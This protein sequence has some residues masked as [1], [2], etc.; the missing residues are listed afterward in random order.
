MPSGDSS[1]H[2]GGSEPNLDAQTFANLLSSLY[3]RDLIVKPSQ[4]SIGKSIKSHIDLVVEYAKKINLSSPKDCATILIESLDEQVKNILLFETEFEEKKQDFEWLKYKLAELFPEKSSTILELRQLLQLKQDGLSFESFVAKIKNQI[5][6]RSHLI[7]RE[8]RDSIAK[9]VFI[10]GLDDL[11]LKDA[12]KS[13][14]PPSLKDTFDLVKNLKISEVPQQF[15]TTAALFKDKHVEEL[16]GDI[17]SL[18]EKVDYLTRC[19]TT[20]LRNKNNSHM[21]V[22]TVA[23][24]RE[25]VKCFNCQDYGHIAR[26]CTKKQTSPFNDV[27]NKSNVTC[28]VC[29]K[30][31]HVSAHCNQKT[32]SFRQLSYSLPLSNKYENDYDNSASNELFDFNSIVEETP[33]TLDQS[34]KIA[35]VN[36]LTRV[37]EK[38]S[39][40]YPADVELDYKYIIGESPVNSY[41]STVRNNTM[42]VLTERN[43]E[44]IKNKPV[45]LGRINGR[46][47]KLFLDSGSELNVID[48]NFVKNI[49]KYD[50]TLLKPC[51]TQIKCANESKLRTYGKLCIKIE[52][53]VECHELEFVVVERVLPSVII[54]ICGMKAMSMMLNL[55]KSCAVVRGIDI[56]F[57]GRV[58][59]TSGSLV[60]NV[61]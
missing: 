21:A 32:K 13:L 52:V 36:S 56:P 22:R 51:S 47:S 20:L 61:A 57:L 46:Q 53:G 58:G 16:K 19:I 4:F 33:E 14:N 3:R 10:N 49:L 25:R 24:N 41:A 54:G 30:P 43:R 7:K 34:S 27:K 6:E 31:G 1:Q 26:N 48:Y 8:D 2:S 42:T 28:Y 15:S 9:T 17:K 11:Y 35:H 12:I 37:N 29:K 18:R 40:V 23:Q 50:C 5:L 38:K 60:K 44:P 59:T 39:K 45:V 55:P